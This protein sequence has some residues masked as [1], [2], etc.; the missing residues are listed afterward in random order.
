MIVELETTLQNFFSQLKGADQNK[1]GQSQ[2]SEATFQTLY[3]SDENLEVYMN[4][5][6]GAAKDILGDGPKAKFDMNRVL[7]F[8]QNKKY[9]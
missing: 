3:G 8:I 4:L 9:R 7:T 2:A 1:S 6:K 5:I